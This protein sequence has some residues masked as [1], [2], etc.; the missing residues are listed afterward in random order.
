VRQIITRMLDSFD[1]LHV[2]LIV[3]IA[4]RKHFDQGGGGIVYVRCHLSKQRE[5]LFF[6]W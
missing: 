1:P 3:T 6:A 5:I 2:F 4:L